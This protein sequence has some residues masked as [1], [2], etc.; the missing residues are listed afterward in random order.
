MP[1]A[2]KVD[3]DAK[4][5]LEELQA[6]IRLRTGTTV[7]QQELLSR[8]IDDAYASRAT[9]VD[10]FRD[11]TVPL[12][13]AEKTA[14]RGGSAL[15][16]RP[17]KTTSTTSSTGDGLRRHRRGVRRPRHGRDETRG[18][19]PGA[20]SS[21][22]RVFGTPYVSDYVFDE[23]VTLARTRTGSHAA[24]RRLADRLRGLDPYPAAYELRHVSPAGFTDA[25]EVFDRYDDQQLSFT[26]ATSIALVERHDL[27]QIL[28]FDDDF[29]GLV[30]RVDPAHV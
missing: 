2:V 10:S 15:A 20:R 22:R 26:D 14:M 21:V 17:T 3:G 13:E 29:D 18:G 7:T 9:L 28:S 1:T 4:S 11:S 24:A 12:S 16:S 27:D 19:G 25:I 8:L 6:E 30:E 23:A 5:R